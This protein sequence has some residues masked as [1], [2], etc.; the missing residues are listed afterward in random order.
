MDAGILMRWPWV[1]VRVVDE[2]HARLEESKEQVAWLREQNAH[3]QDQ[4]VRMQ[5]REKGLPEVPREPRAPVG[6]M[7]DRLREYIE[8]FAGAPTRKQ[9]RD[10]AFRRRV[11]N[12]ESWESIERD[13]LSDEEEA[14]E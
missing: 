9:M 6:K 8:G 1:S 14:V 10:A 3:L 7:P 12:G 11:E 4:I 5:R 13:V 2:A